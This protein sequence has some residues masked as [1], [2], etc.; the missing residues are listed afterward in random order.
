[1]PQDEPFQFN[2]HGQG[3]IEV[4][5]KPQQPEPKTIKALPQ[6]RQRTVR[7]KDIMEAYNSD[8]A[9]SR[10]Y[11]IVDFRIPRHGDI[12]LGPAFGIGRAARLGKLQRP[13]LIL[14]EKSV[15]EQLDVEDRM[16]G[17][18]LVPEDEPER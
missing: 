14:M 11:D 1:M 16:G 17:A 13:Y 18:Y 10:G 5:P 4:K 2:I 9:W 6:G 15:K 7:L 12:Y 8:P 3:V